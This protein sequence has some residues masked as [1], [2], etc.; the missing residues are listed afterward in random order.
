MK[1]RPF[2]S[3]FCTR[4]YIMPPLSS[5]ETNRLVIVT[6]LSGAGKSTALGVLEDLGY[7]AVNNLPLPLLEVMLA[8]S[9]D[10]NVLGKPLAVAIDI[11]SR[12][13]NAPEMIAAIDALAQRDVT[14]ELLFLDCDQAVL[15]QRYTETR[16]RHPL[17]EDRPLDDG[18]TL[19]RQTLAPLK[20]RADRVVDTSTL[21]PAEFKNRMEG[22]FGLTGKARMTLIVTSFGF[23]N[24]LPR[25]ADLVFDVRF[26]RNPHYDPALRPFTG[27]D[28]KV[29]AFV[30]A[31]PEYPAFFDRLTGFIDPLLP[32]Y[33]QEGK[34]YL[35]IAIGCTGGK[36]RSVYTSE[37]LAAWLQAKGLDVVLNH[38]DMPLSTAG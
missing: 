8:Q 17:A 18:L 15:R 4:G 24:G 34:S 7:E 37:Q 23:R 30:A 16:R 3:F 5:S 28:A 9:V 10:F 36:H 38:R 21:K 14:V 12:G 1:Y 33:Q 22:F 19:E 13:F 25:E 6:G 31:D 32:R 20:E 2:Y 27:Q 26:L 35:T 29:G 11:R